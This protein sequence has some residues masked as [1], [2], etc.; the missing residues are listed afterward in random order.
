LR[1]NFR[2]KHV[3]RGLLLGT[4]PLVDPGFEGRL[5]IPLHNLTADDYEIK[6]GEGLIWVEFTKLSPNKIWDQGN[7]GNTRYGKYIPF[8]DK[9][10]QLAP[11][12]YFGKSAQGNPIRSSIP[13]IILGAEHSAEE[14]KKSAKESEEKV[15]RITNILY[16][17]GIV[18]ILTS[19]VAIGGLTYTVYNSYQQTVSLVQATSS[20]LHNSR[21]EFET[22]KNELNKQNIEFKTGTLDKINSLE[23]EVKELKMKIE[24]LS[25]SPKK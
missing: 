12:Q 25:K 23:K 5:V 3:H 8:P 18:A 19:I 7:G 15:Q 1:F 17:L 10:K 14:A 4:G 13:E 21:G 16:G 24:N 20:Y 11:E 22:F 9:G 2:I 6:A